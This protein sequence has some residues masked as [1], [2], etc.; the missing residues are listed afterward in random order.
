MAAC[1]SS[2]IGVLTSDSFGVS[3]SYRVEVETRV[4]PRILVTALAPSKLARIARRLD[5]EGALVTRSEVAGDLWTQGGAPSVAGLERE[6]F[7][8]MPHAS[9]ALSA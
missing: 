3:R 7:P 6:S 9:K 4:V 8:L 5:R 1:A 2:H